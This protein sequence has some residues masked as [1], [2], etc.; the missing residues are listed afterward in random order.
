MSDSED[1]TITYTAPPSSDDVP[2]LEEPEQAPPSPVYLP[3]V[4]EPVYPEYMLPEDDVLPAEE[5]LLPI[6]ASPTTESPGYIPESDPKEDDEEDHEEDPT[7]YPADR[8][9]DEDDEKSSDNDDDVEEDE[10]DED[11]EEEEHLAPADPA[12][13]TFLVDQDPSDEETE[14]FETDESAATPPSPPHPTYRVYGVDVHPTPGAGHDGPAI[15]GA[16]LYAFVDMV[17]ATLGRQMSSE[18][19]YGITD[20]WDDLVGAIQEFA[21]TTQ[22]GDDRSLLRGRVN[23]LFRDRPYH[24]RTA[25]LM[26]EEARVSRAAWAQSMDTCDQAH[27][28]GM[29]LRTTVIAQQSEITELQAAYRR[30]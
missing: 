17:D 13:V 16:D 6:A 30:R 2:G 27:S 11:E 10:E 26:E 1:S 7:D 4:P 21:P 5:Q 12:A 25:L 20:T 29:S 19:D 24:R 22:E 28:K 15:A 9:D 14:P 18:L 3:Y 23:M 8:G